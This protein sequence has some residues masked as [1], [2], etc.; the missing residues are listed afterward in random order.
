MFLKKS[1]QGNKFR[2][3]EDV[4]QFQKEDFEEYEL[5]DIK[6]VP[7]EQF[8]EILRTK[9]IEEL[10]R[11]LAALGVSVGAE[12]P[13]VST[14]TVQESMSGVPQGHIS[15]RM[16]SEMIP[17]TPPDKIY[18]KVKKA[19]TNEFFTMEE[20]TSLFNTFRDQIEKDIPEIRLS[21]VTEHGFV[22]SMV[23][24]RRDL[25]KMLPNGIPL[26]QKT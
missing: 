26:I 10:K 20:L 25:P 3:L 12:R 23:E 17:S 14:P 21:S 19:R 4:S 1:K 22:L 2:I 6:L 9:K 24:E 5:Y 11:E 8:D 7:P 18:S 15:E 16:E 13:T